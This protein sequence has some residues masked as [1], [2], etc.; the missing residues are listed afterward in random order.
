LQWI[1]R[2]FTGAALYLAAVRRTMSMVSTYVTKI[3][4]CNPLKLP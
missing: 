1:A 3:W 2:V 4:H